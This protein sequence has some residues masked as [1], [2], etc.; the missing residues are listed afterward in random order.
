MMLQL[1][2]ETGNYTASLIANYLNADEL[3]NYTH[4]DG[5]YTANQI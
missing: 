1:L 3:Q 2:V 5:I 4:V